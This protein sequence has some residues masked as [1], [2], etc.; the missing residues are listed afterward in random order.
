L[1]ISNDDMGITS[2]AILAYWGEAMRVTSGHPNFALT[3]FSEVRM[4]IVHKPRFTSY[5]RMGGKSG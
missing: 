4:Q 2:P 5:G 1:E 3:E